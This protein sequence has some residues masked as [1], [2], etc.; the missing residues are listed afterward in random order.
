MI[1]LGGAL[2]KAFRVPDPG[3]TSFLAVGLLAVVA[4]L[5]LVDVLFSW[6]MIIVIP[7]VAMATYALAHWV[8]TAFVEPAED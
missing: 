1:Y 7:V 3:S 5:F 4:L 8:T 6:S 2:L